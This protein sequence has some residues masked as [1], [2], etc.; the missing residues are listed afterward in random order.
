VIVFA[1]VIPPTTKDPTLSWIWQMATSFGAT[2]STDL[3]G[4]TTHLIAVDPATS[5]AKAARLYG[6]SIHVVTPGWLLDST[7]RWAIQDEERYA[8]PVNVPDEETN[9]SVDDDEDERLN[10][11]WAEADREV[12]DFINESGIDDAWDTDSDATHQFV[13]FRRKKRRHR[14]ESGGESENSGEEDDRP[15]L[16]IRRARA[17]RRGKSHLSKVTTVSGNTTDNDMNSDMSS[18]DDFAGVLDSAID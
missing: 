14:H 5:K 4:K 3:T 15:F 18:L 2:C 13:D 9:T 16:A 8:L 17:K 1:D 12:E 10:L 7:A 11:D 6:H